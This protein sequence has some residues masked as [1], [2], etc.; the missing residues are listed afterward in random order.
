MPE[1]ALFLGIF[2]SILDEFFMIRVAG[3]REAVRAGA[4]QG[5]PGSE[6]ADALLSQIGERTR[7]LSCAA[8]A[9]WEREIAPGLRE[10]GVRFLTPEEPTAEERA[11]LDRLFAREILLVLTPAA[12]EP[13][14]PFPRVA[15]LALTLAVR[16]AR[17]NGPER[18]A[19]VQLPRMS[20]RWIQVGGHGGARFVLLED[21][22]RHHLADLFPGYEVPGGAAFRVTR[23]ADFATD[24]QDAEDL[25]EAVRL[26]LKQRRSGD[27]VRL[28][29][30]SSASEEIAG[31]LQAALEIQ[32][33]D[34]H[35]VPGPLD[36]KFLMDFA[37]LPPL[38]A[39][40]AAAWPPQ[41]SPEVPPGDRIW[42]AIA[43]RDILL[44][45]PYESFEPVLR[46]LR[47]A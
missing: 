43:E 7:E 2:A 10:A 23:D 17:G 47:L 34:I 35:R 22:V 26:M 20:A 6:P 30:E 37:R 15:N 11:F 24:D 8:Y 39:P 5:A 44:F 9:T 18:F 14:L 40:R 28:E 13:E 41:P 38:P 27:P 32:A 12:V 3:L 16:V 19:M 1:R 46:V 42:E 25:V 36:L 4:G 33:E 45:H 29:I 21:V 31:R